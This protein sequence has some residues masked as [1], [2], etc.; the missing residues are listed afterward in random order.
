MRVCS[1]AGCNNQDRD[2]KVTLFSVTNANKS[3][4]DAA[5]R[6]SIS[7]QVKDL[8]YVCSEHFL[9]EDICTTYALP[10]DVIEE[11]GQKKVFKLKK[12]AIPSLFNQ[13]DSKQVLSHGIE[14][15]AP[16]Q[17]FRREL[18]TVEN[19]YFKAPKIL[20]RNIDSVDS[21]SNNT[22]CKHICLVD[23]KKQA[24]FK[25]FLLLIDSISLPLGW[26]SYTNNNTV[27][28][29]KPVFIIEQLVI[30]KQIIIT[31][32]EDTRFY[33]FNKMIDPKNVGL[34]QIQFPLN[35]KNV[36][37]VINYFHCKQICQGGPMV[38][39]FPGNRFLFFL[40]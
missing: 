35:I 16:T 20:K 33:I 30:E 19:L 22:S 5:V 31:N 1:V 34:L 40:Y 3:S 13:I 25:D 38:I 27:V 26:T 37:E 36:L 29:Y 39:N 9:P 7:N 28:F 8:K 11:F 12:G 32:D 15:Q 18:F 6:S 17:S 24:F 10:S 21:T 23:I 4:W 14:Y 2:I